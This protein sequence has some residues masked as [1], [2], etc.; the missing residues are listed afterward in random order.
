MLQIHPD[1]VEFGP[2]SW[3]ITL[4]LVALTFGA[5]MWARHRRM[6][7]WLAK[8]GMMSFSVYLLHPLLLK[9]SDALVGRWKAYDNPIP[10]II[11]LLV[12]F[13]VCWLTYSFVEKPLQRRGRDLADRLGPE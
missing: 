10:L 3:T 11:F 4:V 1:E 8:L 12:L 2:R 7:D 6:P 9:V 13:P 5:G